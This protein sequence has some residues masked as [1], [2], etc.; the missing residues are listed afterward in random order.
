LITSREHF[1]SESLCIRYAHCFLTFVDLRLRKPVSSR[2]DTEL[3]KEYV[4][5]MS[6]SL[7]WSSALALW[8]FLTSLYV[9]RQSV[10][11][12]V[13]CTASGAIFML[14]LNIYG[15]TVQLGSLLFGKFVIP[16]IMNRPD[17]ATVLKELWAARWNKV[18]QKLLKDGVYIPLRKLQVSADFASAMTFFASGAVHTY[19]IASGSR[20]IQAA[21][22]MICYFVV[23]LV[24]VLVQPAIFVVVTH[25]KLRWLCTIHFLLAPCPLFVIPGLNLTKNADS[26]IAFVDWCNFEFFVVQNLCTFVF[27]LLSGF[28]FCSYPQKEKA[29][30]FNSIGTDDTDQV[31]IDSKVHQRK[32]D[33]SSARVQSNTAK[34]KQ[35]GSSPAPSSRGSK[36]D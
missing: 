28:I 8:V 6:W 18:I 17:N 11:L 25:I 3:M 7:L 12:A 31:Q 14:M 20:E 16:Q 4:F 36:K 19:I 27:L 24:L 33:S 32:V 15:R 9:A 21:G 26:K 1:Q 29:S 5:S 23:Q 2:W 34:A 30:L 22:L 35:R 13:T 10:V